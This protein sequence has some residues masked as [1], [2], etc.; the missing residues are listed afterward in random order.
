MTLLVD[1][2]IFM[3]SIVLLWLGSSLSVKGLLHLSKHFRISGFFISFLI[4]GFASTFPE[5]FISISSAIKGVPAVAVGALLGSNLID[6]TIIL[7]AIAI[8]GKEMNIVHKAVRLDIWYVLLASMPVLL[9]IDNKLSR[10]DGVILL[11]A[12]GMYVFNM[13]RESGSMSDV[14]FRSSV[15]DTMKDVSIFVAGLIVLFFGSDLVVTYAEKVAFGLGMPDIFI[16]LFLVAFSTT[17]PEFAFAIKAVMQKE[18]EM[19]IGDIFGNVI[20]DATFVIALIAILSPLTLPNS[21]ALIAGG[22]MVFAAMMALYFI[23]VDNKITWKEGLI[24]FFIYYVFLSVEV[25][26]NFLNF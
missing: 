25:G 8:V 2:G 15:G 3:A 24:L 18:S 17:L 16:G 5:I 6:M 19:A 1:G 21:S 26:V 20:I 9:I 11:L 4:F 22:F 23:G 12:F 10:V 14:S 7:G 13:W